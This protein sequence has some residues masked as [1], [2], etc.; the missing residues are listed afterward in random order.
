M[1]ILN[2]SIAL[3]LMTATL[4]AGCGG[5]GGGGSGTPTPSGPV[6]S[7]LSFPL[8][9]AHKALV[10]SG[11][12]RNFTASIT[13]VSGT[14]VSGPCSATGSLSQAPA[15]TVATFEGN[16]A[17]LSAVTTLTL[18]TLASPGCNAVTTSATA[19]EYFDS[20]FVELGHNTVGGDYGVFLTAP[21]IPASGKV[22]DTGIIGTET[23]YT[24]STKATVSGTDAISFVIEAD[25]ATSAIVNVITKNIDVAG[26]VISTSQERSRITAVGAV[27]PVSED[28]QFANGARVTI[29]FL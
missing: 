14:T 21:S 3:T 17:A 25:T 2:R 11:E 13:L 29:Q 10:A 7:T 19:T 27:T 4:L 1:R 18:T 24:N 8:Q 9:S 6:T 28:T 20:N 16:T 26:N 23:L 22:G 5:G 12:T 15:A